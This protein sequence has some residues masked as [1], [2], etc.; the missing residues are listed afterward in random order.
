MFALIGPLAAIGLLT[1]HL[2]G[3]RLTAVSLLVLLLVEGALAVPQVTT[4][5]R[6]LMTATPVGLLAVGGLDTV[7]AWLA[8]G[9]GGHTVRRPIRTAVSYAGAGLAALVLLL[10]LVR[11]PLAIRHAPPGTMLGLSE[12]DRIRRGEALPPVASYPVEAA[13]LMAG[14]VKPGT[15]IYVLGDPRI[16]T[17]LHAVQGAEI[18]GWTTDLPPPAWTELT[19]ELQRSRPRFFYMES[20]DWGPGA[21]GIRALLAQQ[22]KVVAHAPDGTWYQTDRPG[23]PVPEP[24]GNQL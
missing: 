13:A 23:S 7:L 12:A 20:R 6:W 1:A 9:R 8:P 22:Y 11:V 2:R 3:R 4:P 14:K 10:P 16:T 21:Q 24:G 17:L 5:Y 19:R 15:Q 18:S